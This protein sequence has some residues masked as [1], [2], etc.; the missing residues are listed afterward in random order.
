[1]IC[2]ELQTILRREGCCKVAYHSYYIIVS[3]WFAILGGHVVGE[4]NAGRD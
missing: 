3:V 1:M 2:H 4:R